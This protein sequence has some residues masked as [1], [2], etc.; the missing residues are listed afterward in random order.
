MIST[1]YIV[2]FRKHDVPSILRILLVRLCMGG[3]MYAR[4]VYFSMRVNYFSK[5]VLSAVGQR[6]YS[7]YFRWYSRYGKN[8]MRGMVIRVNP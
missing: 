8:S 7:A 1:R 3:M 5:V 4:A 2:I 6:A